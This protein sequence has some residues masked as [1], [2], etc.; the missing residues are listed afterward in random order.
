MSTKLIDE[1]KPL[2]VKLRRGDDTERNWS[3]FRRVVEDDIERV[4]AEFDTRWLVS[5]CDTYADFGS[6]VE[7]RNAMFVSLLANL[8]KTSQS[9]VRWRLDYPETLEVP[10]N[11]KPRKIK[12][13]DGMTS[14]HLSIGDVTNSFFR[15]LNLLMSDTPQLER[16]YRTVLERIK[17]N[18]TILGTLNRYHGYVFE[19]DVEWRDQLKYDPW[20][21]AGKLPP[22]AASRDA[23]ER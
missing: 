19:A 6:A 21:A 2:I 15:R 3:K 11:Q 10:K 8:E 22:R 23:P 7:A 18:D 1:I 13:W 4:C 14:F 12:L 16:I 5:V 17:T 20:R 9:Y